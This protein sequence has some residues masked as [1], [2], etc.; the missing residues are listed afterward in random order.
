MGKEEQGPHS[1]AAHLEHG[2]VERPED[3]GVNASL[4][5]HLACRRGCRVLAGLDVP[6]WEHPLARIP[7]RSNQQELSA[8]KAVAEDCRTG[9]GGGLTI[10]LMHNRILYFLNG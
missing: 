9:V 4:L 8:A 6:L 1:A 3:L 5:T 10:G 2:A 7:A